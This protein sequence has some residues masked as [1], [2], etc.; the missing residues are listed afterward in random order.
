VLPSTLPALLA[1]LPP[2]ATVAAY[3]TLG[4]VR[5]AADAIPNLTAPFVIES[6]PPE[7]KADRDLFGAAPASL[8]LMRAMK[9]QLDP[10]DVLS[11]G[12]F[13]GR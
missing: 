9:A 8:P 12:R 5:I 7:L 1:S 13:V 3:P 10:N 2:G 4:V 11:P 6:C